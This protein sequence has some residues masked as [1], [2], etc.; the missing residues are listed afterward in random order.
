VAGREKAV[1]ADIV[2]YAASDLLCYRAE[3]PAQLVDRQKK[4]W[5]PVL[6]WARE[7][8]GAEMVPGRGIVHVTQPATAMVAIEAAL[9][10]LPALPL[11]ALHSVTTLTGSALLAL[12]CHRRRLSAG[13]AWH[14]AHIDEDFQI[15]QWGEDAEAKA[16]RGRKWLEMHAATLVLAA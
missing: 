3:H 9:A 6:R 4:V 1:R 14:L 7:Q 10:P 8:L 12:A 5:D 15:E 2:K 11:A 16:A 13:Q